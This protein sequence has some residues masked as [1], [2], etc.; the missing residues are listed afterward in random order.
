MGVG[1]EEQ[2]QY[3]LTCCVEQFCVAVGKVVRSC[4]DWFVMGC[5]LPVPYQHADA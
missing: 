4:V 1:I 2:W 3:P 5:R